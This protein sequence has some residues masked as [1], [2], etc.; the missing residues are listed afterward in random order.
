MSTRY[1]DTSLAGILILFILTLVSEFSTKRPIQ[2]AHALTINNATKLNKQLQNS[3]TI[4]AMGMLS[5]LKLNWQEQHSKVLILQ[6]Q[7]ADKTANLSSLSRFVRVLLQ[8][9]ALGA[10]ALL[11]IGGKLL[12]G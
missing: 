12:R 6:T 9:V 11:V 4:E 3:D 8:S 5:T 2:Q 7:I 1:W 10:G